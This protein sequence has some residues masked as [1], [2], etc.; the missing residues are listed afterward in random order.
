MDDFAVKL[1]GSVLA[2]VTGAFSWLI[3][4]IFERIKENSVDLDK[5]KDSYERHRLYVADNYVKR[6]EIDRITILI[7]TMDGK[8]EAR[9]Q[10]IE[11]KIDRK[12]DK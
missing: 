1:I 5:I 2:V 9:L 10:R 3:R 12:A 4:L 8:L 11:D 7:S 6:D